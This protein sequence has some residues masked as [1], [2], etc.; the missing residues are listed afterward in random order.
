MPITPTM[1]MSLTTSDGKIHEFDKIGYFPKVEC[2]RIYLNDKHLVTF[3]IKD[4]IKF[5][6]K[7]WESISDEQKII[8]IKKYVPK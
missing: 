1:K 7:S 2:I 3:Y 6:G 5:M 4:I 8:E